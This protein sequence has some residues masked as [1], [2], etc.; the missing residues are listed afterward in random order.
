MNTK[1]RLFIRQIVALNDYV[2]FGRRHLYANGY[3]TIRDINELKGQDL[4]DKIKEYT[5]PKWNWDELETEYECIGCGEKIVLADLLKDG[6]TGD[7]ALSQY[8]E[9]IANSD[10]AACQECLDAGK[11]VRCD[12]CKTW[13]VADEMSYIEHYDVHICD[14]CYDDSVYTCENCGSDIIPDLDNNHINIYDYMFCD[15]DCARE[16]GY[17]TC[18]FCGVWIHEDDAYMEDNGD[19]HCESCHESYMERNGYDEDNGEYVKSYGWKPNPQ[20]KKTTNDQIPNTYYG[21]E[22]E[23]SGSQREAPAF[24]N[25]F[26]DDYDVHD[27]V[28]LKSDC[29]IVGG[30]FEIVTHPMTADY[31]RN[32]FKPMLAAGLK[33]LQQ[34]HFRGHNHGGMHIHVSRSAITSKMF[35]RMCDLLYNSSNLDKWLVLTQRKEGELSRWA[36]LNVDKYAECDT[37]DDGDTSCNRYVGMNITNRTVEF[38]IFN[39]NLRLERVLKNLELVEALVNFSKTKYKPTMRMFLGYIKAH[40]Q[41]YTNVYDF[42]M[43][44]N[45]NSKKNEFTEVE[46]E[47]VEV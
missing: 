47:T 8:L 26:G 28:Y 3:G 44:K 35:S 18:D 27:N 46:N 42:I 39:S 12:L 15:G 19:C 38:R 11:V 9:T 30:G 7:R 32:T 41:R 40:K 16:C 23:V 5:A 13:H 25:F 43:E 10:V 36:K 33:H 37:F 29:S 21:F 22:L 24:L 1:T 34:S 2:S 17:T 45:W 6:L 31:I 14:D 20:F 4:I